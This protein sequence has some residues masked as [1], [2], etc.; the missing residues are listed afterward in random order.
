MFLKETRQASHIIGALHR[1]DFL[2]TN[3]Q[4]FGAQSVTAGLLSRFE[5]AHGLEMRTEVQAGPLLLGGAT[6]DYASVSGRSY[7][8][9]PGVSTRFAASFGRGRW[10]YLRVSHEQ[11][12]IHSISGNRSDHHISFTRL[13][14]TA[15]VKYNVG[16]MGEYVLN[17]SERK[18]QD[19]DDVSVRDPQVKIALTWIMD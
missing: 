18:Y 3:A 5:T 13:R 19:Y 4:E 6:S 17:L 2:N 1:F 16:V 10:E 9:G 11:F 12:W 15:P 7:D 8:Y 14:F